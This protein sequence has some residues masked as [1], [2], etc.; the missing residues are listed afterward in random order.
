MLHF[1]G[2]LLKIIG[3]ILAVILGILVLLVC[4]V[5]LVPVRYAADADF[6]GN[7]NEIKAH[8]SVSWLLHLIRLKVSFENGELKWNLRLAWLRFSSESEKGKEAAPKDKREK[9]NKEKSENVS[10]TQRIEEKALPENA[11][12]KKSAETGKTERA[13]DKLQ[14]AEAQSTKTQKSEV[15]NTKSKDVKVLDAEHLKKE[16]QDT[17]SHKAEPEEM[18]WIE[19]LCERFRKIFEKIKYTFR[20]IC[21]KIKAIGE[22]KE[23]I[24]EFLENESH[25]RAF[26]KLMKETVWIRRFLRPKEIT[27]DIHFGFEDPYLTGKTLALLSMIYPFVGEHMNIEPDFEEKVLEGSVKIRGGLRLFHLAALVWC[28]IWN[29]DIRILIKDVRKRMK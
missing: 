3:I 22:T 21:D 15:Q 26:A 8:G 6:P 4:I 24:T 10:K 12:E 18:S 20:Q 17:E 25:Q 9:K 11:G 29:R 27:A 16:S 2:L 13:E 23:Q 1:I 14:D 28:L 19:K 7:V 5:L